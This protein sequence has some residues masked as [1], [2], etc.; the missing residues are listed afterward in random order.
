MPESDSVIEFAAAIRAALPSLLAMSARDK[1][2]IDPFLSLP[3]WQ[4]PIDRALAA[5]LRN[6]ATHTRNRSVY[7][8]AVSLLEKFARSTADAEVRCFLR[9]EF[10]QAPV[11]WKR[12][13]VGTQLHYGGLGNEIAQ[14][15][16]HL[17]TIKR[18]EVLISLLEAMA[19][20]DRPEIEP[21][22]IAMIDQHERKDVTC[23][24][25]RALK[26]V[27]SPAA[28]P[29]LRR[30]FDSRLLEVAW[31]ATYQYARIAGPSG[32]AVYHQ[33]LEQKGCLARGTL[34]KAIAR[35]CGSAGVP[36]LIRRV[37]DVTTRPGDS[38]TTASFEQIE[39]TFLIAAIERHRADHEPEVK[40]LYALVKKR[41]DKRTKIERQW[42]VANV[43]EFAGLALEPPPPSGPP[44]EP[45]RGIHFEEGSEMFE[46]L[47]IML[48]N[49]RIQRWFG[50]RN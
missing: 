31:A 44:P 1:F 4:L 50:G 38:A 23:Y 12:D 28:L 10:L 40:K 49:N 47:Q 11:A 39:L 18:G 48:R 8:L 25:I 45:V 32:C 36:A 41:W 14:L 17:A 29:A 42:L 13:C 46:K 37:K 30:H 35:Y 3:G 2:R 34:A 21:Y 22:L 16:P 20:C 15:A 26:H 24:A 43:P 19:E 9:D 5:E 7:F 27:G 33:A 6:L